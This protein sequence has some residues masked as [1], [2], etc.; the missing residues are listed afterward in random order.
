MG[1]FFFM[2]AKQERQVE[3]SH[4]R[5]RWLG[6]RKAGQPIDGP[7]RELDRC[8]ERAGTDQHERDWS[9]GSTRLAST[10]RGHRRVPAANGGKRQIDDTRGHG[11]P[12]LA[13]VQ[14]APERP[15]WDRVGQYLTFGVAVTRFLDRRMPSLMLSSHLGPLPQV[16]A[17]MRLCSRFDDEAEKRPHRKTGLRRFVS[18]PG[19]RSV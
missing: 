5:W 12:R 10:N 17:L 11:F 4:S 19:D 3:K 14:F 7:T 15:G 8:E 18:W 9:A 2:H 6:W 1:F 13:C 16:G